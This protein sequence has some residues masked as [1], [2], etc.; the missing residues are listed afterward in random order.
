M[1]NINEQIEENS[2]E[3]DAKWY[4]VHTY[5]GYENKVKEKIDSMI[6]NKKSKNIFKTAIPMEEYEDTKGG[7]KVIKERKLLPGYVLIKMI[8]DNVNWYLIRNTR[9]VT[10]FV[11]P[12]SAD[13]VELTKDEIRNFGLESDK[14]IEIKT[15]KE[16]INFQVGDTITIPS[17]RFEGLEAVVEEINF[18][19]RSV[20]AFTEMFGRHT[21]T[22]IGFDDLLIE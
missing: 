6:E 20:R 10:G 16:D 11:G 1:D 17:G 9:G 2:L 8:K 7:K 4:V 3:K 14:A 21:T 15:K 13:P 12:D 18:E 5:S 19:K 22:D